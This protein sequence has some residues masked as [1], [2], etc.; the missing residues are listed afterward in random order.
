MKPD[1]C[2]L[3]STTS[4]HYFPGLSS[5]IIKRAIEFIEYLPSTKYPTRYCRSSA[6]LISA[7]NPPK[8]EGLTVPTL[9]TKKL[10]YRQVR[11]LA[12]GHISPVFISRKT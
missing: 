12:Q 2:L 10:R 9:Q 5:K 1:F 3:F 11:E 6:H 7:D 4:P 8:R